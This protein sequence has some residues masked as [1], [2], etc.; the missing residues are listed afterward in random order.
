MPS[1]F[2]VGRYQFYCPGGYILERVVRIIQGTAKAK[3]CSTSLKIRAHIRAINTADRYKSRSPGQ[4][5][6]HSLDSRG[7]HQFRRKDLQTV[8]TMLQ[9]RERLRWRDD[10]GQGNKPLPLCCLYNLDRTIW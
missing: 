2:P 8:S 10:S 7:R 6:K 1:D 3:A 5:R 4:Y 9:C